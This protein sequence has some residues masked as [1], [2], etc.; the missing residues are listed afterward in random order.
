MIISIEGNIGIGKTTLVKKL[1]NSLN[2][3]YCEEYLDDDLRRL[4]KKCLGENKPEFYRYE[5]QKQLF[6]QRKKILENNDNKNIL[7]DRS[8]LS[9][10]VFCYYFLHKNDYRIIEFI[11][12]DESIFKKI[13]LC[14]YLAQDPAIAYA[15]YLKR[16]DIF[17]NGYNENYFYELEKFHDPI[18][19]QYTK[20][21]NIKY[22][23]F[24][25]TKTYASQN[26]DEI[27]NLIKKLGFVA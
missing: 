25:L 20:M 27:K 18:I 14:I 10:L 9:D 12:E 7:I 19:S 6:L 26:I 13:D 23:K 11:K 5:F 21:Y 15:N 8:I 1:A 17:E 22:E 16:G 24:K 2:F 3:E 4:L